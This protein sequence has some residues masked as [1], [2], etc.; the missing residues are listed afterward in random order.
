MGRRPPHARATIA[1]LWVRDHLVRD[2][3]GGEGNIVDAL[4]WVQ[5]LL[6]GPSDRLEERVPSDAS[7]ALLM[8]VFLADPAGGLAAL[9]WDDIEPPLSLLLGQQEKANSPRLGWSL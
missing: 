7:A 5:G 4:A 1:P 8:R 2:D 3:R 6:V 9:A